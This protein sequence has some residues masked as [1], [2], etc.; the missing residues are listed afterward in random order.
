MQV[1]I[2]DFRELWR[3]NQQRTMSLEK[4]SHIKKH[5]K[6]T[7][8]I[9]PKQISKHVSPWR[10]FI[11]IIMENCQTCIA[12]L[13]KKL[14]RY[15]VIRIEVSRQFFCFFI[16]CFLRWNLVFDLAKKFCDCWCFCCR[17]FWP[18]E[19]GF[20]FEIWEKMKKKIWLMLLVLDEDN[21]FKTSH[22]SSFK[23]Q[24]KNMLLLT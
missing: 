19:R 22:E 11:L 16:S 7:I 12:R 24:T 3:E 1:K 23:C 15:C 5:S 8:K 9:L 18:C 17:Y 10:I 20:P 4:N 13:S 14:F 6:P 21:S 2:L